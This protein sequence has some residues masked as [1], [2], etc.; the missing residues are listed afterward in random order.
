M[1]ADAS[2]LIYTPA[3]TVY[4]PFILTAT[5]IK[6]YTEL[7]PIILVSESHFFSGFVDFA[8][9]E[10]SRTLILLRQV[11]LLQMITI[12]AYHLRCQ[13]I[14]LDP[15]ITTTMPGTHIVIAHLVSSNLIGDFHNVGKSN[16]PSA[17]SIK[18]S[19]RLGRE[20]PRAK[21]LHRRRMRD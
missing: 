7:Q 16:P 10:F 15:H 18:G 13:F 14:K 6:L 20:N 5:A 19:V 11:H 4:Q 3:L 1:L 9:P 8:Y 2:F 17:F 12:M 21:L